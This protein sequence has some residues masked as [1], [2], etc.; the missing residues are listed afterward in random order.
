MGNENKCHYCEHPERF[1]L[2]APLIHDDR[3][4]VHYHTSLSS[5]GE[6]AESCL[7]NGSFVECHNW[8]GQHVRLCSVYQARALR[9]YLEGSREQ[10]TTEQL[11]ELRYFETI[12]LAARAEALGMDLQVGAAPQPEPDRCQV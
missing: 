4:V 11:E 7:A 9:D 5:S 2:T 12:E 10:P 1:G 8:R 3:R 6:L